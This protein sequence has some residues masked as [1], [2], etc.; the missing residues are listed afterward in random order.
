MTKTN[1]LQFS[2]G[3]PDDDVDW[4]KYI[5]ADPEV[6]I[7]K[8]V[9]KGTRLGVEFVLRLFA[10]GWT[11]ERVYDS[12]PQLTPEMLRAI[13][14]FAI[15][16]IGEETWSVLTPLSPA[17]TERLAAGRPGR[18]TRRPPGGRRGR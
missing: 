16:V 11:H 8:P 15:E 18:R 2:G 3:G 17:T 7:G 4:R 10:A 5:H 1:D 6:L 14:A 13:F 12:Y 9:L